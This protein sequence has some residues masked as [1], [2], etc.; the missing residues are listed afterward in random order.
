VPDVWVAEVVDA[1]LPPAVYPPAVA[2]SVVPAVNVVSAA[3][4]VLASAIFH[5]SVPEFI[6]SKRGSMAAVYLT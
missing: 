1:A 4:T 6:P 2:R 5:A 3:F